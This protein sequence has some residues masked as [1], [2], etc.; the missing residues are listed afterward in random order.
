ML[1]NCERTLRNKYI[2]SK[3]KKS[4]AIRIATTTIILTIICL[5]EYCAIVIALLL[6]N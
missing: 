3:S 4:S 1:I 2:T 6:Y 5:I